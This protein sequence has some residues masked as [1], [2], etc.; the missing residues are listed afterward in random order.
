MMKQSAL[1]AMGTISSVDLRRLHPDLMER[2]RELA[3]GAAGTAAAKQA[4]D[5]ANLEALEREIAAAR[6]LA[7]GRGLLAINVMRAVNE[8]APSVTR[9]LMTYMMEDPRFITRVLNVLW[10]LRC[11]ERIGDHARNI[12]EQLIYM[13]KGTDVRHT[14]YDVIEKKLSGQA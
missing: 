9:A 10:V 11:L 13:V 6:A 1:G 4:I 8:Y 14:S 7:G 12:S 2:T 5:E 3:P